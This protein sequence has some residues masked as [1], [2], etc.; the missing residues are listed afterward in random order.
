M[1]NGDLDEIIKQVEGTAVKTAVSEVM[2]YLSLNVWR[3][4]SFPI[5]NP[6]VSWLVGFVV[7]LLITRLDWLSYMLIEDW[8]NTSQAKEFEDAAQA[9]EKAPSSVSKEDLAILEK[10][11][12]DAFRKLVRLGSAP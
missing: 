9:Y 11:K 1:S 8:R 10:E 7:S 4:F 12:I 2:G 3:G 5:L 6:L